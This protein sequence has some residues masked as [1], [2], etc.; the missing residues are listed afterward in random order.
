MAGI[1]SPLNEF[2]HAASVPQSFEKVAPAIAL[3]SPALVCMILLSARSSR[4]TDGRKAAA[5]GPLLF[6]LGAVGRVGAFALT[7]LLAPIRCALKWSDTFAIW[8]PSSEG[9]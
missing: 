4:G 1:G 7:A 9:C 8:K 5:D 3:H 6:V 2:C